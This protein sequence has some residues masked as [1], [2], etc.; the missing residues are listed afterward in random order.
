MRRCDFSSVIKL[1]EK[2]IA[3][4]HLPNQVD[5]LYW[6]FG[7]CL[8]DNPNI[9][10]DNGQVCRWYNGITNVSPEIRRYYLNPVNKLKMRSDIAKNVLPLMYDPDMAVKEIFELITLD[11]S[12]DDRLKQKFYKYSKNKGNFI[13]K[14][15]CFVLERPFVSVGKQLSVISGNVSPM[16]VDYIISYDIPKPVKHFVGRKH[17]IEKIH[18]LFQETDKIFLQGIAG[19]GK[20]EIA[21]AYVQKYKS[22][23][24]NIL[25]I[26]YSGSLYNDI[27]GLDF[28]TDL[29]DNTAEEKFRRHN[30]FLQTLK[31]DTLIIIDNFNTTD[32]DEELLADV[33]LYNCK[34]L[35][36]TRS[37]FDDG[38]VID[39]EEINKNDLLELVGKLYPE[40]EENR[41]IIEQLIDEIHLHT[42]GIELIAR[43]LNDSIL[44]PDELLKKIKAEN[45][46]LNSADKI[47]AV[48]D[49]SS[50]K[51]TFYKH[52]SLLFSLFDLSDK[53]KYIMQ[54]ISVMPTSGIPTRQFAYWLDLSDLNT[55]NEL[56]D[57]G[58]I[59][60]LPEHRISIHPIMQEITAADLKPSISACQTLCKNLQFICLQ[61]H[62]KVEWYK[63]IFGTVENI[64]KFAVKDKPEFYL[65]FIE[66]VFPYM[67]N[68][69][70][71]N[72]M[73]IIIDEM[74]KSLNKDSN[75]RDK[76]LLL[77]YKSYFETDYKKKI[78]LMDKALSLFDT[79]TSENAQLIA[80]LH[81]N[82]GGAYRM[83]GNYK[84]A[85]AY[86]EN[87]AS[88]M[89]DF[90]LIHSADCL[91]QVLNYAMLK[92]EIGER[93]DVLPFLEKITRN[94]G[95]KTNYDT[96]TYK[97]ITQMIETCKL[98]E[99]SS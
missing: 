1:I 65:R 78:E 29:P 62:N 46:N 77:D 99:T 88:I 73:K 24:K 22:E 83:L 72:G 8:I 31:S 85:K 41:N 79:I 69:D 11:N 80:N 81:S 87:G 91:P 89:I 4:E 16:L 94:L 23:Y 57:K 32:Y 67:D 64:I 61:R 9:G 7:S 71:K 90:G 82:I 20:S 33:L 17:E 76:A 55:V 28:V 19:I 66:D 10:L 12:V 70:Y 84:K 36:T 25:Y 96:K 98:S 39:V 51:R 15:I 47:K 35:F 40:T 44:T 14:A 26:P 2:Y 6:I 37:R 38:T 21:K 68:Y 5:L 86:M 75:T 30:R 58:F 3:E 95:N 13:S 45:I 60:V 43:L 48:K 52:I 27:V 63:D 74:E 18:N 97:A 56:I 93:K 50:R 34:I 92:Q 54:N 42:F 53:Q 59:N 49:N